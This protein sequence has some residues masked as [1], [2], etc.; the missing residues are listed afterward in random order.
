MT[1]ALLLSFLVSFLPSSTM[2]SL[3]NE[4]I[5]ILSY[6]YIRAVDE[7]ISPQ[8]FILL[9]NCESGLNK[10]A[11]GDKGKANGIAQFWKGTYDVFAKQY[12]LAGSYKNPYSQ[13]NLAANMI[14]DNL[15]SHWYRCGIKSGFIKK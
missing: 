13:I 15:A 12:G 14:G 6:A 7:R 3:T 11:V 5:E 4:H 2:G 10:K 1:I 8:K 9:L